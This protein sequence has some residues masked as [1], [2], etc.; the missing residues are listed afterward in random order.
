M[1]LM[2]LNRPDV[3]T[4]FPFGQ[5]NG[6]REEMNR[7]FQAPFGDVEQ[8]GTGEFFNNWAPALDLREDKDSLVAVV[9][10]PGLKKEDIDVSVHEG[11]LNISGERKRARSVDEGGTYRNER[12]YGRFHRVISLPKPVKVE[13]I[14][15]NYNDGVL[16]V[17]MPKTE[18]AKPKQIE[19]KMG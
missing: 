5:L 14:K 11:V 10:L 2:T 3:W 9:E 18:A 13:A 6:L 1:R 19:V 12:F 8:T 15:A 17:T 4:V 16:T 7:L